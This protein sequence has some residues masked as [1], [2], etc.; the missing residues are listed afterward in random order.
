M[1]SDKIIIFKQK[2][3]EI[4]EITYIFVTRFFRFRKF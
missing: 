3:L 4:Q 1:N 2:Y